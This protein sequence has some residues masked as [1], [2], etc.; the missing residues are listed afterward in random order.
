MRLKMPEIDPASMVMLIIV[1]IL[2]L[3]VAFTK[4]PVAG[5]SGKK[6]IWKDGVP[7]V[8]ADNSSARS[9]PRRRRERR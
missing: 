5:K 9:R 1:L 3:K 2:L 6:I 4:G 8:R 7:Y